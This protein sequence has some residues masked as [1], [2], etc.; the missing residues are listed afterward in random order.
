VP[1]KEPHDFDVTPALHEHV[2]VG[3]HSM[4]LPPLAPLLGLSDAQSLSQAHTAPSACGSPVKQQTFDP[5]DPLALVPHVPD[6]QS[7]LHPAPHGEPPGCATVD[8]QVGPVGPGLLLLLPQP[9]L[10]T[11]PTSP[12]PTR[13]HALEARDAMRAFFI[14]PGDSHRVFRKAIAGDVRAGA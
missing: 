11:M 8:M 5:P 4:A 6:S 13:A 9:P 1:V 10:A 7:L 12:S 3:P 2:P 14:P